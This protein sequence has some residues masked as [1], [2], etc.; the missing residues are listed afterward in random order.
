MYFRLDA[1]SEV[2]IECRVAR[3]GID[4]LGLQFA[5]AQEERIQ[6][7]LLAVGRAP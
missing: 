6:C 7:L 3:V 1:H 4:H 2:A 5:P